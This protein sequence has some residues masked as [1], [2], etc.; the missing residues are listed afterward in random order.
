[1][2]FFDLQLNVVINARIS[3]S[4]GLN[5]SASHV[6][7]L[8]SQIREC[9]T[10]TLLT[11]VC[12]HWS[13]ILRVDNRN[14]LPTLL[15]FI[16]VNSIYYGVSLFFIINLTSMFT[17]TYDDYVDNPLYDK[18]ICGNDHCPDLQPYQWEFAVRQVC[19][20][21]PHSGWFFPVIVSQQVLNSMVSFG[22]LVLGFHVWRRGN[23]LLQHSG[24]YVNNEHI[25]TA[26]RRSLVK[27][28]AVIGAV[29]VASS[30]GVIIYLYL[31]ISDTFMPPVPWYIFVIWIPVIVPPC[32]LLLLQ[33][34]PR[35]KNLSWKES[36]EVT[37]KR[38]RT[39]VTAVDP[40]SELH[41]ETGSCFDNYLAP[42]ETNAGRDDE[43]EGPELPGY[44]A[45]YTPAAETHLDKLEGTIGV[46]LQLSLPVLDDACSLYFIELYM[47]EMSNDIIGLSPAAYLHG[48]SGRSPNVCYGDDDFNC[49]EPLQQ[50]SF[51]L[52][53]SSINALV[54]TSLQCGPWIGNTT[55][56]TSTSISTGALTSSGYRLS[57][58]SKSSQWKRIGATEPV[59][60]STDEGKVRLIKFSTILQIAS[61]TSNPLVRF[62]VCTIPQLLKDQV[63]TIKQKF[64][65]A[66]ENGAISSSVSRPK[67]LCEFS[68]FSNE[69]LGSAALTIVASNTMP[70]EVYESNRHISP[71]G[72]AK[73]L[74]NPE[75][76]QSPQLHVQVM[77][78]AAKP[79]NESTDFLI[80][81]CFQFGDENEMVIE[82]M[83][84]CVLTNEIPIQVLQILRK[85]RAEDLMLAQADLEEFKGKCQSGLMGGLYDSVIDQIQDENDQSAIQTWLQDRVQKRAAYIELMK[86]CHQASFDRAREGNYF[87]PSTE[88]KNALLQFLPVNMVR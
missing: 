76:L 87:R 55:A 32:A 64:A 84:E 10:W 46:A 73:S 62:V 22:L 58:L 8:I 34:N 16:L 88:R 33:W 61:E 2:Q 59:Q 29:W 31:Y 21:V 13:E 38:M 4:V 19:R 74:H 72:F 57:M 65:I 71:S 56:N 39:Q 48:N 53:R 81:R 6:Y 51:Q 54:K 3:S 27:F 44:F 60:A 52:E 12:C 82:D 18:R 15:I 49:M 41:L 70:S 85:D 68:C 5:S 78:V 66:T 1:M 20:D 63:S 30:I 37:G 77:S 26:M 75:A 7:F 43:F 40:E 50:S 69:M 28:V 42:N 83:I 79:L 35:L 86:R 25:L 47:L 80:S 24:S 23:R 11:A 14:K 45:M 67:L 17:C 36:M 9:V